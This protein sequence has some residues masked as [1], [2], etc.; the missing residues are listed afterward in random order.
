MYKKSCVLCVLIQYKIEQQ[1]LHKIM[2]G[3]DDDPLWFFQKCLMFMSIMTLLTYILFFYQQFMGNVTSINPNST[4][5]NII[6]KHIASY[7]NYQLFSVR[8]TEYVCLAI[9]SWPGPA[10]AC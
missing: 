7:W 8:S 3:G 1:V 10:V 2:L 4:I 9:D 6:F 5:L